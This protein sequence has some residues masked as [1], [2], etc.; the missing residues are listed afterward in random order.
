MPTLYEPPAEAVGLSY[1]AVVQVKRVLK[2]VAADLAYMPVCYPSMEKT[3]KGQ[4]EQQTKKSSRE[5][6]SPPNTAK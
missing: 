4:Q 6:L 1:A 5:V 2:R 3:L